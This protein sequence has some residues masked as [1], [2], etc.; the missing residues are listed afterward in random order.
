[1]KKQ[2]C[3]IKNLV[4]IGIQETSKHLTAFIEEY[5]L[6][7]II[8]YAVNE[9]YKDKDLFLGKPVFTIEN[10]SSV[11]DK[12]K[13]FLFVSVLWNHLNGDRRR[14]YEKLKSEGYRF[15]NL[16]SPKASIKGLIN[17]DNNWI[18]DYVIT[19]A[20]SEIGSDCYMMSFSMLGHHARLGSHCFV[21]AKSLIGGG[22]VI[23]EQTFIGLNATIFGSMK[24]GKK[25]IIGACTGVKRDMPDFSSWKTSSDYVVK[26][27]DESIIEEKLVTS[28]QIHKI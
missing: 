9:K 18:N 2:N 4:I 5:K 12:E 27:Y 8:G 16:I 26:T 25:C 21:G 1:M 15:A 10:L 23:G 7:N 24:V 6:F 17:G 13:D 28:K 11:I 22:C 19:G 20:Y 14:L 3:D